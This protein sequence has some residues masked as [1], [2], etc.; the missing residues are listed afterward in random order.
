[1][2]EYFAP[3]TGGADAAPATSNGAAPA[4]T[5]GGDAAM[6]DEIL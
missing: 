3:G 2:S 5:N 6:V 1:M 4:A